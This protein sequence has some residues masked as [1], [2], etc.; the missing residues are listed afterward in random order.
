MY[1]PTAPTTSI[2]IDCDC[3]AAGIAISDFLLFV[4]VSDVMERLLKQ[5]SKQINA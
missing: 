5:T 4:V 1:P 3:G 2:Q